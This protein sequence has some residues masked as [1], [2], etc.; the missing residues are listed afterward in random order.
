LVATALLGENGELSID[1]EDELVWAASAV[2][3]GGLDTAS[4]ISM[5]R[6]IYKLNY[7]PE[8]RR[9]GLL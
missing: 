2:M 4:V 8:I 7:I 6:D 5:K 3:G 1:D 9:F